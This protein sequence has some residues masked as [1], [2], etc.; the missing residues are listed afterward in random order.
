MNNKV[1]SQDMNWDEFDRQ[2]AARNFQCDSNAPLKNDGTF[3]PC[4]RGCKKLRND[5]ELV[6]LLRKVYRGEVEGD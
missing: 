4:L 3:E 2:C 6:N 5:E 1:L